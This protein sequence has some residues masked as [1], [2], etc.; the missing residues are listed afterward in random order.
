M[1]HHEPSSADTFAASTA[2]PSAEA[3]RLPT[4]VTETQSRRAFT[5]GSLRQLV[6]PPERNEAFFWDRTCRGFGIRA[7]R[8]GRRSWIYQYRDEHGRTRRIVLGD[9]TAVSLEAARAAARRHAADVVNG[10]N[11]SVER[12]SKRSRSTV[13]AVI[14]PYLR[15]AKTRLRVRSFAETERHLRLHAAPLH[16]ERIDTVRRRDISASLE[17]VAA[18]SGPIAANRL[19]AALSALWSWGLRTGLIEAETNPV[20]LTIRYPEKPRERTLSDAEIKAIWLASR[21]DSDYSRIVRLCLLTGGRREEIGGLRWDEVH[22]DRLVIGAGRMKGGVPHEIALLPMIEAGLPQRP[23]LPGGCVFGRTGTGFSGWSKS[24]KHLDI[25]LVAA[26]AEIPR[27]T[28]HDLRRT[29]STRLHDAGA[30]PLV[31]EALLAHKQQGVAAVYNRASFRDAKRAALISWH[32]IL[33]RILRDAN[34]A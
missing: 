20:T 26:G 31:V 17:R 6:C 28:L 12:K 21:G 30:E 2:L 9:V 24:K 14:D 29:V 27:W 5:K 10:V 16:H 34:G 33:N 23:E 22:T 13:V 1:D 11:P 19:R 32:E 25:E 4:G 15:H 8:S 18:S 3:A 7:L